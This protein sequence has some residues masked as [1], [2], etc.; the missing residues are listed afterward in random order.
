MAEPSSG[1]SVALVGAGQIAA[2]HLAVL[3]RVGGVRVTAVCDPAIERARRLAARGGVAASCASLEELLAAA[4]PDAAHVLTPPPAHAEVAE[5]LLRAGVHVLVEKPMCL[6]AATAERLGALAAERGLCLGVNHNLTFH[7]QLARLQRELAAGL[8]GR[9]SHVGLVHHVPLRQLRGGPWAQFALAAPANILLEQGVHPLSVAHAL[10][11]EVH[12][13]HCQVSAPRTLPDGRPFHDT[14]MLSLLGARGSAQLLLAFGREMPEMTVHAIGSDG[15]V[16]IDLL[17]GTYERMRKTTWPDAVDALHNAW[18]AAGARAGQGA[19]G[20]LRYLRGLFFGAP[21]DPYLA[22]M[23]ASIA[24]FHAALARGAAAPCDAAA[25]A[26]VLRT[27]GRAAAAAG[28]GGAEPQP[29]RTP[30]PGPARP[31]EVVLTGATGFVGRRVVRQVVAAGR[32]LTLLV[33]RPA[34]L[35]P[36]LADPTHRVFAGDV[37]VPDSLRVAFTGASTVVHLATG[38]GDDPDAIEHDLALGARNVAE[39]ALAA[40]VRRLVF[41]SSSAALWLGR[42]GARPQLDSRPERRAPYARGKIAAERLLRQIGG[43]RLELVVLRPAIVVGEGG[44]LEHSGV[45]LWPRDHRCIGWGSGRVPLPFVL[46]DDVA[47]AIVA[48]L[49]APAAA[50]S[51]YDLAGGVRL[52]AADYVAA[53]RAATGR[54]YRFHGRPVFLTFLLEVG[55]WL[56]KLAAR[57]HTPFPSLRDLR[58]RGFFSPIDSSAAARDLGWTPVSDRDQFLRLA[59]GAHAAPGPAPAP[60]AGARR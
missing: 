50:G 2:T 10:L 17:R 53:L 11:G 40:G 15:A 4:R 41:L 22:S 51:C 21:A 37:H 39:A 44:L 29:R 14:W 6:E 23:Q 45:G 38:A 35:L 5:R 33:R 12:E 36:E 13:V 8:L 18:V 25:A 52:T 27:C 54:D 9:L 42:R 16:R 49:D 20:A 32:P 3:R 55:K 7:A 24:A 46:V 31:G 43:D 60:P 56:I 48:A 30:A 58:S 34:E 57:R 28:V 47:R 26:A 59:I 19:R 1:H